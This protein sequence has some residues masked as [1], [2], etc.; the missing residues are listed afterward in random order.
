LA[1]SSG[2]PLAATALT[3]VVE[4]ARLAWMAKRGRNSSR[5][6]R[7]S[8]LIFD[9]DGVLVDVHGSFHRTIIDTVRYFTGRRVTYAQIHEW[10]NRPG[11]NDDWKLTT[12]WVQELGGKVTYEEVFARYN[13]IF[14]GENGEGNVRRE[15]WLVS[16]RDVARWASRYELAIFTGRSRQE[17]SHTFDAWPG[18]QHFRRIVTAEDVQRGKPDPEGLLR[19][20]AGSSPAAALY[21]GDNIDDAAAARAARVPFLG[22]LATG[23]LARRKQAAGLKKLGALTILHHV[24]EL[25]RWL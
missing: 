25:D 8:I 15:R 22:V 5:G 4:T 9:V 20:L 2:K 6:L 24:R 18:R 10:K 12:D 16:P 14:W 23:S 13:R 21:L 11:Y 17:L 1:R 19:A 3:D 7:P